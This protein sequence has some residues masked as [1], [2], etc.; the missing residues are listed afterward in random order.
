MSRRCDF[1]FLPSH[2]GLADVPKVNSLSLSPSPP[3]LR[4]LPPPP[5]LPP[6]FSLWFLSLSLPRPSPQQDKPFGRRVGRPPNE[7]NSQSTCI[8]RGLA[9]RCKGCRSKKRCR[10][11]RPT[12]AAVSPPVAVALP[13]PRSRKAPAFFAI[14]EDTAK[15]IARKHHASDLARAYGGPTPE[16]YKQLL[17]DANAV[18]IQLGEPA[19]TA[20]PF[21]STSLSAVA[22]PAFKSPASAA[23]VGPPSKK[24]RNVWS[25][26]TK[27]GKEL[28]PADTDT[29]RAPSASKTSA[30]TSVPVHGVAKEKRT[31]RLMV[32]VKTL[33]ATLSTAHDTRTQRH[34]KTEADALVQSLMEKCSAARE[35]TEASQLVRKASKCMEDQLFCGDLRRT[36]AALCYRKGAL[37]AG[38][39]CF[40]YGV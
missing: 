9:E 31:S 10:Q 33:K 37:G 25:S 23:S 36:S 21:P 11:L 12:A 26:F 6:P 1:E 27:G 5:P 40:A 35:D 38:C 14:D 4:A 8:Q 13:L 32:L 28:R 7:R 3:S 20:A 30:K 2:R 34:N 22:C 19:S 39:Y 24:P 17:A 16:E 29:E 15:T 18:M